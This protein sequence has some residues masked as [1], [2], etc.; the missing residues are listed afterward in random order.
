M[1]WYYGRRLGSAF[2]PRCGLSRGLENDLWERVIANDTDDNEMKLTVDLNV[3]LHPGAIPHIEDQLNRILDAINQ[4]GI[5]M[6][7]ELADLTTKVSDTKTVIDSA[8]VLIQGIKAALDAAGSNPVAL[9]ALS[10]SLAASDAALAA[11]IVAN[12]PAA[13][14][15]PAPAA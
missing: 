7:N 2:W 1:P 6:A 13:P 15:A 3:F 9:K 8:I 10:D 12:T 11:A 4:L 5:K 14:P